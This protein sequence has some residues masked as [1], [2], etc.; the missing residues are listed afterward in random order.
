MDNRLAEQYEERLRYQLGNVLGIHADP[1]AVRGPW[2]EEQ[3]RSRLKL[4][5][6]LWLS[7]VRMGCLRVFHKPGVFI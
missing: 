3:R 6:S 4:S 5:I 2:R 1:L 7:W